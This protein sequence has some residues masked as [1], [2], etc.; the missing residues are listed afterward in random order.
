MRLI[1]TLLLLACSAFAEIQYAGGTTVDTTITA[2]TGANLIAGIRDNLVTAGWT[3]LSGSGTTDVV[4]RS[5]DTPNGN[6][7]VARIWVNGSTPTFYIQNL[8]GTKV[9]RS[10]TLGYGTGKVYQFNACKHRFTLWTP[11][12]ASG[13]YL[14][15]E[16]P[17]VQENIASL[18]VADYGILQAHTSTSSWRVRLWGNYG[19]YNVLH[20]G[21]LV[22]VTDDSGDSGQLAIVQHSIVNRPSSAYRWK[23]GT[24]MIYDP[25]IAW[26]DSTALEGKIAGQ[27]WQAVVVSDS[28]PDGFTITYDSHTWRAVTVNNTSAKQTLFV[29]VS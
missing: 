4:I 10:W 3:I 24:L 20:D 23:D 29:M 15:V 21:F 25:L 8:A 22:D 13:E 12:G 1:I 18:F 2:T 16:V 14:W 26:G 28:F 17:Y 5:A 9:G 7:V 6:Y 27:L 11:G 19:T